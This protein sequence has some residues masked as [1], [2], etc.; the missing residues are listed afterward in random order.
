MQRETL[1][2]A[3]PG[4]TFP[5]SYQ[6]AWWAP[7]LQ[8]TARGA[9]L[10]GGH[11]NQLTRFSF[12][13]TPRHSPVHLPSALMVNQSRTRVSLRRVVLRR[14]EFAL[15]TES[16]CQRMRRRMMLVVALGVAGSSAVAPRMASAEG[17]FKCSCGTASRRRALPLRK[18]VSSP[19]RSASPSSRRPRRRHEWAAPAQPL[20]A[21]LRRKYFQVAARG[22]RRR[23]R[24]PGVISGERDKSLLRQQ[25]RL[26]VGQRRRTLRQRRNAFAYRKVLRAECTCNGRDPA[27]LAPVDLTLDGWLRPGDMIATGSGLV[28]YTGIRSA[29]ARRRNSRRWPPM[30]ASPPTS[31]PGL[32]R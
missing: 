21:Q 23:C 10:R 29:T 27:G 30:P 3:E 20:R 5:L 8:R 1:L 12:R 16:G 9:A 19:I 31:A 24:W 25:H 14:V 11:E 15:R 17:L 22:M 32:A 6:V 13:K 7:A 2:R 4:P 28:A 18:P 26:C